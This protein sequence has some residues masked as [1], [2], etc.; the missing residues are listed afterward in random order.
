MPYQQILAEIS[1]NSI[2][3]KMKTKYITP[4]EQFLNLI[5]KS[6]KQMQNM[7]AC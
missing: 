5:E 2:V 1:M 6:L 7:C 4:S 3:F